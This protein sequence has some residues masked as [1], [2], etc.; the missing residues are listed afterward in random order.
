MNEEPVKSGAADYRGGNLAGTSF[1]DARFDGAAFWRGR[2]ARQR[3]QPGQSHRHRL[4]RCRARASPTDGSGAVRCIAAD[5][6]PPGVVFAQSD[7]TGAQL[8]GAVLT[9]IS[10]WPPAKGLTA[11]RP[12][13]RT[14]RRRDLATD[15]RREEEEGRLT[16]APR[17]Q[18]SDRR[19][20]APGGRRRVRC[21]LVGEPITHPG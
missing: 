20:A 3:L 12:L 11:A 15:R 10:G 21:R 16:A 9:D 14:H 17:R 19:I 13:D 6:R 8:E 5:R 1:A 18:P 4:H 2:P 7:L